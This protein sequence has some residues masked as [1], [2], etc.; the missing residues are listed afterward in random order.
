M[1]YSFSRK[2]SRSPWSWARWRSSC[3]MVI[4]ASCSVPRNEA[5][6]GVRAARAGF[7]GIVGCTVRMLSS[8]DIAHRF[9]VRM[10]LPAMTAEIGLR[11]R[12]IAPHLGRR[13]FRD[14][15][16]E[17]QNMDPIGDVHHDPYLALDHQDGDCQL[18]A[19]IEH[20]TAYV[21]GLLLIRD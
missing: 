2:A 14:L 13:P 10:R 5:E 18:F 11:H 12:R 7:A 16:P 8:T 15:S 20:E 21:F 1:P 3:G 9:L 6:P 17:V 19:Y 4:A